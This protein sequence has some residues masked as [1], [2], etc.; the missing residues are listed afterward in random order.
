MTAPYWS[1]PYLV[2][3]VPILMILTRTVQPA[4]GAAGKSRVYYKSSL[5]FLLF[6]EGLAMVNLFL[7]MEQQLFSNLVNRLMFVS[8]SLVVFFFVLSS[9]YLQGIPTRLQILI[10]A[11]PPTLTVCLNLIDPFTTVFGAFGWQGDISSPLL[12][13]TW[14]TVT[15]A[16]LVWSLARLYLLRRRTFDPQIR[17][18][19]NYFVAGY[20]IACLS[21]TVV[22]LI[23]DSGPELSV[24]AVGISLAI[25]GAAFG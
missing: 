1:L 12:R 20:L 10:A 13:Y 18:R 25:A 8:V 6:W 2:S 9:N 22:Y 14:L 16:V 3:S 19:L 15:V 17:T 5:L 24:V 11:I 4:S 23:A 7:P 21:G